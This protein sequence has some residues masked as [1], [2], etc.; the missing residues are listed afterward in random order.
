MPS[1]NIVLLFV[2][3]RGALGGGRGF[4]LDFGY[5]ALLPMMSAAIGLHYLKRT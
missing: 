2:R 5:T 4:F 1:N 3:N